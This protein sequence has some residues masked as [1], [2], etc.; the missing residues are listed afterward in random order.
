[1]K[2]TLPQ[3]PVYQ[4]PLQPQTDVR[5][6]SRT[7]QDCLSVAMCVDARLMRLPGTG[8]S[9]CCCLMFW[10]GIKIFKFKWIIWILLINS[11]IYFGFTLYSVYIKV[12]NESS[13]KT[14]VSSLVIQFLRYCTLS[15]RTQRRVLSC[16]PRKELKIIIS[17]TP[18]L[19][20]TLCPAAP[21]WFLV[22]IC[23]YTY[24]WLT[25]LPSFSSFPKLSRRYISIDFRP[26]VNF[27]VRSDLEMSFGWSR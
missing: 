20:H 7:R 14:L 1:M 24:S 12:G 3:H 4:P 10:N 6:D 23:F 17:T 21:R 22:F 5:R 8:R 11:Y 2:L 25:K 19:S 9:S 27:S 13:V 26:N 15:G 18:H 16:Y